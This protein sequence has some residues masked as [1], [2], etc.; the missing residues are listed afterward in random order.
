MDAAA[1]EAELGDAI[2]S[3]EITEDEA[4]PVVLVID[5]NQDLRQYMSLLLSD[6]YRVLTAHDGPTGI[7]KAMRNVP[8]LIVCDVMMPGMDGITCCRRLKQEVNTCHIPV[9]MLTANAMD[10]QR[11]AGLTEGGADAFMAKPFS[12]DVLRAQ[13]QT[14]IDNHRRQRDFFGSQ[15]AMP[16]APTADDKFLQRMR[17]IIEQRLSD[18]DFG[19]EELGQELGM[20]RAQL[21]RKTKALTNYSPVELIRNFRLKRA[22][23]LLAQGHDSIAQ[24]AYSVGFTAP[25]YFTKCYKD[26]FGEMPNQ[27]LRRATTQ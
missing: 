23:Q 15:T 13:I 2:T 21:Y 20:S 8:D 27:L 25:S 26:Y 17:N 6:R 3:E 4:K 5:D 18:S 1:V 22:Q 7:G 16:A 19:V 24:V 11:V 9:L 12:P 10:E 14:L